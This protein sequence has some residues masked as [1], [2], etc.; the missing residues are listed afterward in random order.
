MGTGDLTM[1]TPDEYTHEGRSRKLMRRW[2]INKGVRPYS[3]RVFP[4]V[5]E[6]NGKEVTLY[7][8]T[9]AGHKNLGL[10]GDPRTYRLTEVTEEVL[11]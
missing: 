6:A 4:G 7:V 11:P 3:G 10:G 5:L 9:S 8:N 1:T 2:R